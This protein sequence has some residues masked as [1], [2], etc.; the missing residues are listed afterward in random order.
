MNKIQ[1][2]LLLVLLR[3]SPFPVAIVYCQCSVF[4]SYMVRVCD[5]FVLISAFFVGLLVYTYYAGSRIH[6]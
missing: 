4:Y 2:C 6:F 3:M 5:L 1:I